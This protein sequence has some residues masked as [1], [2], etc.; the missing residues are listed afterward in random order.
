MSVKRNKPPIDWGVQETADVDE[1]L[2]EDA[3][4]A[5]NVDNILSNLIDASAL[6]SR[7]RERREKA[8]EFGVFAREAGELL[9]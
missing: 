4:D 5:L 8:Y 6:E 9:H 3:D 7:G 2:T 1:F